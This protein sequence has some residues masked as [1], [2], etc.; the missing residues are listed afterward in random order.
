MNFNS[1][2]QKVVNPLHII[3]IVCMKVHSYTYFTLKR[4]L[5]AIAEKAMDEN[6]SLTSGSDTG[7][8]RNDEDPIFDLEVELIV[9]LIGNGIP[10]EL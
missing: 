1:S 10:M 4:E 6:E 8:E 9:I 5:E 2:M 7:Y 3:N